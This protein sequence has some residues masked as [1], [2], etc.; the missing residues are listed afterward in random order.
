MRSDRENKFT[1][2]VGYYCGQLFAALHLC[3]DD[4]WTRLKPVLGLV[5]GVTTKE[6]ELLLGWH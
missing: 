1:T 4:F 2:A 6:C 3:S 5:T